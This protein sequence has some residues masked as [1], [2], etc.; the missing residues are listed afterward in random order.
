VLLPVSLPPDEGGKTGEEREFG[1]EVDDSKILRMSSRTKMT[2]ATHT[3]RVLRPRASIWLS[4]QGELRMEEKT[5]LKGYA[6]AGRVANEHAVCD[7]KR[8]K[9]GK[10]KCHMVGRIDFRLLL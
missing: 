2:H 6:P 9:N 4:N 7:C 10:G 3:S 5:A 1:I 8:L